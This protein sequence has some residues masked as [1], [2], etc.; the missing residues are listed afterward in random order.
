[1]RILVIGGMNLDVLGMSRD[2][3]RMHDSNIGQVVFRPG[4]VARNIAAMLAQL[5]VSVHLLTALGNDDSARMLKKACEKDKIDL[6]LSI[7]TDF[8][9]PCYLCIHDEKG[10]MVAAL[11]DMEAVSCLTPEAL[12]PL[13]PVING[14]DVCVLDANLPAKTLKYLA[15][16]VMV[17]LFLDPVSCVKAQN[18]LPILPRLFAI[19]PNQMEAESM[20]GEKD[21][22]RAAKK[23][24][25]SGVKHVFISLGE[26]GVY[27][28]DENMSGLIPAIPLPAVPLTGAGDALCAGLILALSQGKS[29]RECAILG[30]KNAYRALISEK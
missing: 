21:A 25:D 14:F 22:A 3:F 27:Y 30:V 5:E 15:E 23:L 12:R 17:P 6:S 8:S 26:K 24:F 28:Q 29:A 7:E 4:G 20:T 13:L 10:D 9:T 11:N 16:E 19:K 1:M 2:G 18:A